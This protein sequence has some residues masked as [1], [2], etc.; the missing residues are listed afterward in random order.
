MLSIHKH[1]ALL[2]EPISN[3][4]QEVTEIQGREKNDKKQQ[5]A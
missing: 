5:N 3:R 2:L 4:P 1:R